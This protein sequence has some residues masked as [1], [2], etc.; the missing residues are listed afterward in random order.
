[1]KKLFAFLT[2]ACL[3]A[4]NAAV[5]AAD[6][7]QMHY[8]TLGVCTADADGTALDVSD[9]KGNSTVVVNWA[10][11][12]VGT[13]ATYTGTVTFA[14]CATAGGTFTTV[15]NLAGT[16]GTFIRTGSNVA[17]VVTFQIDSARLNKYVRASA[18]NVNLTNAVGVVF[19][20]PMKA[21]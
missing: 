6:A 14:T 18:V 4:M 11:G 2:L 7:N 19:V 1:M 20:A 8:A 12:A 5:F 13:D 15:T 3:F 17:S 21:D 16:A 10:D 9:Y